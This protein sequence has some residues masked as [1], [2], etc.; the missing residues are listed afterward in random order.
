[1]G[2]RGARSQRPDLPRQQDVRTSHKM[3]T[4]PTSSYLR[5][6]DLLHLTDFL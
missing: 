6:D 4:H 1:M 3:K 2:V 5:P